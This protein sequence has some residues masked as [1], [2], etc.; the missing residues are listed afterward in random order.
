MFPFES[1]PA[2]MTH[3]FCRIKLPLKEPTYASPLR[4]VHD[5]EEEEHARRNKAL[6][7]E[8]NLFM[9]KLNHKRKRRQELENRAATFPAS[10]GQGYI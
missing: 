3:C 2:L 7:R 1:T 8:K 4:S 9:A 6:W 10:K 5:L